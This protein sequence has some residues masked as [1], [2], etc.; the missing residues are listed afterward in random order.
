M[1]GRGSYLTPVAPNLNRFARMN[2][3]S[4][5]C[6]RKAAECERAA[7]LATTD[8]TI[9]SMYLDL[10]RQWREMAGRKPLSAYLLDTPI[11]SPDSST[12]IK[13]SMSNRGERPAASRRLGP[14]GERNQNA[15]VSIECAD[16]ELPSPPQPRL[17]SEKPCARGAGLFISGAHGGM[18]SAR[19]MSRF[20]SF[21]FQESALAKR[22]SP[23]RLLTRDEARRIA[24]NIAKLPELLSK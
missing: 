12:R 7:L 9:G 8:S 3:R 22:L 14:I 17:P 15:G 23:A 13:P 24:V 16:G 4:G 18:G 1:L 2:D 5:K 6:R 10:A 20:A 21:R 11:W 19:T